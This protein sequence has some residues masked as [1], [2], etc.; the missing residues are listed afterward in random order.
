MISP[1]QWERI[2][3]V[4]EEA[5]QLP[6]GKR[7]EW[8]SE[9]CHGNRTLYLQVE[10]L[11]LAVDQES[12]LLEKQVASY[13]TAVATAPP[14]RIG[15]YRVVSE[16]GHGGMGTVYLAERADEQYQRQVAI[17]II[18][19]FSSPP[20]ELLLRFRVE[21]QILAGLQHPNIAQMLDGEPFWV[22]GPTL[23]ASLAS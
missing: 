5:S 6:P 1:I 2:Q 21:R 23:S 14:E 11:L 17:K 20:R 10:S 7:Q 13:A 16:V 3:Q 19:S 15:P 12:G 8:L 22:A 9:V 18:R 4:F